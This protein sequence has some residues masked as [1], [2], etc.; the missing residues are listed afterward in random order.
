MT[1]DT[2]ADVALRATLR[3]GAS[4]VLSYRVPLRLHGLIVPG[5]LVW[6][7]LR[8]QRV[9]GVVLMVRPSGPTEPPG[10]R[11]L[12]GLADPEAVLTA[13]GLDLARWVSTTYRASLAEAL[14]LL[15]PPGTAQAAEPTWRTSPA[16]LTA[17]LGTLP[18]GER[19]VL[20]YL[21][22]H[23]EISERELRANLRGSDS[24]LR[25]LYAAL[26]E[27]GLVMQGST[28]SAPKARPRRERIASLA[29][30]L[31]K[32]DITL[33]GLSR[34]PKQQ[35]VIRWM[36]GQEPRSGGDQESGRLGD[37]ETRRGGDQQ[38]RRPA[39][40]D[41]LPLSPSPLL[42]FSPSAVL[43]VTQI[44]AAT[45]ADSTLLRQ[46]EAKELI[47][48][49]SRE[50]RRDPLAGDGVP[51]D[52]PPPLTEQQRKALAVIVAAVEA[53]VKREEEGERGRQ[54][55]SS[56]DTQVSRAPP[57]PVSSACFMLH[58]VTGSGKTEVYLRAIA[59]VLRLGRQALVLV[60]EI[61]LTTQ[62]VRR[63]AA[64]FPG[65][66]AVLHS[67]LSLGERYDEWR[68][69]RRGV[70]RVAIGSRS[71]VFA[72]LPEL[73]LIIVDEEHELTYKHDGSPR[74]HA[75]DAALQL[76]A[77][78]GCP[79]VLGSATPS[80]ESYAQ[81]RAG[82]Y[83]LI[84][85]P[86][87]VGGGI[88]VDGLPTSTPLPL[89]PVRLV[90]MRREL[91]SGNR[92]IFSRAL[93]Q[94]LDET[95][96][97]R[98]Q[99]ILFLN[100]RGAAAFV[101]C[102]DCGHVVS[103]PACSGPLTVHYDEE[104]GGRWTVDGDAKP[105]SAADNK[106][107]SSVQRPASSVLL[108][109]SCGYSE[110]LPTFCPQCL[111]PRIKAF[112]VGTQRVAEEVGRLFPQAR[113][114]RWDRDSVVGKGAHGR[115]LDTLLQGKADV[116]VGTQMI[117][118]GLDLPRVSLVGVVSAD[119]GLHLPDFRSGERAFQLLTQVAGR[120]GRRSAG[121]QV[122]IQT[123]NPEH[124]ALQATQEHD[125]A[126]FYTQEI[127][128]RRETAYP[129]YGRLVRFIHS[130]G[131]EQACQR[132]AEALSRRIADLLDQRHLDGWGIVGPAPCFIR[133]RWR[134]HL[135]LRAPLPQA[136]GRAIGG[137]LDA[138]EPLYGWV[139]DVDPAHVL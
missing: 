75:R 93:H 97:R 44:Y 91:Q 49:D 10:L 30:P 48:L 17:D 2:I 50:V 113:V 139:V 121:S 21:R 39:D 42:P 138:L 94:A 32:L 90:D 126:A 105:G 86:E 74:Y 136:D 123:Y 23:G 33:E 112:G 78:T 88:G 84:A 6:A 127:A 135:L 107:P 35:A 133:R 124:Y 41:S 103:C 31:D 47:R 64:R 56:L 61:A 79:V 118:K 81:A 20:Y 54:G 82:R 40:N 65:Q 120:A 111:S 101:M 59:R 16:G 87:R 89:P 96:E 129:P 28:I 73:G 69:L 132:E 53:A 34:A 106:T 38:T 60:P 63:F 77:L 70:A 80:V 125:F 1:P 115:M 52:Q 117:A 25:Q 57:L 66:L 36:A 14:A 13:A 8:R 71:A 9:Q 92:S 46:L 27:R 72:P 131:N 45:G 3:A 114:L 62:L 116:L 98:E 99:A 104:D 18:E 12:I 83:Q 26:Y 109:H 43:A 128:F 51:R 110:L 37:Q 67:G 134:W 102:R 29:V 15:L 58:G 22:N 68:R 130:G 95:L 24:D 5:R 19:A 122:L 7:P 11:E 137:L 4:A 85:M 119:T 100:R 55:G 76:G 108:C